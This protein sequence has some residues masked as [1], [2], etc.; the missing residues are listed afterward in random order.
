MNSA[1][2]FSF[3]IGFSSA[4][5]AQRGTEALQLQNKVQLEDVNIQG[6]ANKNNLLLIN[7]ERLDLDQRIKVRRDFRSEIYQEIPSGFHLIPES[8][9]KSQDSNSVQK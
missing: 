4:S 8:H 1:F 9:L 6:E 2:F 3:I 5:W 7:R